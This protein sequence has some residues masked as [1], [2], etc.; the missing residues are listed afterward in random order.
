MT[1]EPMPTDLEYP[2]SKAF[3]EEYVRRH[4]APPS[5]PWP[6]YAADALKVIAAAIEATGSTDSKVLADYIRK[7][8]KDLPGITG[9]ISFDDAG[10]R[11]GAIYLAYE[12]TADGK[13]KPYQP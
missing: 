4:G 5:S 11:E 13:F 1:Q 8:M 2:E 6:V 9:P 3:I 12:V 7:D 10:D